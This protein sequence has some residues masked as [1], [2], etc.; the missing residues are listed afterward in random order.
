MYFIILKLYAIVKKILSVSQSKKEFE[1][2][3]R[4]EAGHQNSL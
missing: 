2:E 1:N 4:R 3:H